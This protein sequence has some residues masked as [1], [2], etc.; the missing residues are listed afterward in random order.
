MSR[1]SI[2]ALALGSLLI[3]LCGCSAPTI[4]SST[5]ETA[6][7][8][9]QKIRESLPDQDRERFDKALFVVMMNSVAGDKSLLELASA[10]P[11]QMKVDALAKLDGKSA[12]EIFALADA[13]KEERAQAERVQALAEIAELEKKK[14]QAML[15]AVGLAKFEVTRSRH[16]LQPQRYGS[17]E[18]LIEMSVKNNTGKPVSRAYFRGV[19]SSPGRSVPW[20]EDDF[21]YAIPG[22]LEHGE[23]ADWSLAPNMFSD[24]GRQTPGDAVLI[25]TVTRLDG[26]DGEALFD[27]GAFTPEMAVRLESLKSSY[28]N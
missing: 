2:S 28:S 25:L 17:P 5:Q 13:I 21:N 15:A 7:A 26:A 9:A 10:D 6:K 18:P 3:A 20:I 16:Y 22:G 4:D 8:S 14:E 12:E 23:A 27:S 1:R 11:E 19:V 24:W